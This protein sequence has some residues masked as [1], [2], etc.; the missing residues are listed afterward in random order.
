[1]RRQRVKQTPCWKLWAYYKPG[2]AFPRHVS[3][4]TFSLAPLLL[5]VLMLLSLLHW[6]S[7]YSSAFDAWHIKK[8]VGL[9]QA[10]LSALTFHLNWLEV[11]TCYLPANWDVMWSL[12][13]YGSPLISAKRRA[14]WAG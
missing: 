9:L 1:M 13:R 11:K 12:S 10:L 6:T 14:I 7:L 8:A 2:T 3:A 5:L 4:L